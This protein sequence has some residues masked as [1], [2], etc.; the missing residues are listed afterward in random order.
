MGNQVVFV[1][2]MNAFL[3]RGEVKVIKFV[4]EGKTYDVRGS[5]NS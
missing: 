3:K 2:N 4:L 5:E 1:H